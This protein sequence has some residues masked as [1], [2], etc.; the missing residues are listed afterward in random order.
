MNPFRH[1]LGTTLGCAVLTLTLQKSCGIQP[2]DGQFDLIM[3]N[4][5]L[6]LGTRT[7][8]GSHGQ[9]E[10]QLYATHGQMDLHV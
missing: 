8:R 5:Q 10:L 3:D 4:G 2:T 9:V 6:G 1:T 7:T